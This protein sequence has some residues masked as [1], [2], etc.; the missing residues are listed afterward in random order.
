[1]DKYFIVTVDTEEAGLWSGQ[2]QAIYDDVS[3]IKE[4]SRVQEIFDRYGIR[5]SYLLD[6][7]I[8]SH[9][10]SYGILKKIFSNGRCEIGAHMHPWCNPPFEEEKSP[11]NS[12]FCNLDA[13]LQ[14]RKLK[15]LTGVIRDNFGISPSVFRAGRF[16]FSEDQAR[17]LASFGYTV[18]SSVTPF[19]DWREDDGPSFEGKPFVPYWLGGE[20]G[21]GD[22][23]EI[24][25][26]VGF[27]RSNFE[28]CSAV[29]NSLKSSAFA[30][31]VHMI[32]ILDRTSIMEKIVLTPESVGLKRLKD[33][34]CTYSRKKIPVLNMYFHS[35]SLKPGCTPYVRSDDDLK[36]F[37]NKLEAFFDYVLNGLGYKN[38]TLG[39]YRDMLTK[40]SQ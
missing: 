21:R 11:R 22:I 8:A 6:Y 17:L 27:N 2:F 5:P 40:R 39:G 3:H 36:S 23:L 15:E 18:D 12:F 38:T 26:S 16:G 19:L 34:A 20:A 35:S 14:E 7:P 32:G 1:M 25:V 13:S 29:F 30:R 33:L 31:S 10:E 9:R 28:L 4:I 24:P 37:L